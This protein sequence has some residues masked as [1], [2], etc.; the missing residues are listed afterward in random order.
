VEGHAKKMNNTRY[1]VSLLAVFAVLQSIA[2]DAST[3]DW[4]PATNGLQMSI[5]LEGNESQAKAGSPYS[6]LIR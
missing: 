3:E 1:A 4:G 2:G 5:K 6:L